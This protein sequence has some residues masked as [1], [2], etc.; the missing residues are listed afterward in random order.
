MKKRLLLAALALVSVV[1]AFALEV[2]S[3]VYNAAGERMKI[4]GE[5]LVANG[6]FATGLDGWT[7]T[8]ETAETTFTVVDGEGPNGEAVLKSNGAT[9]DDVLSCVWGP[10]IGLEGGQTYVVSFQIKGIKETTVG[11]TVGSNYFDFFMN[12]DGAT[13]HVASTDEAPVVNI[14]SAVTGLD[15]DGWNTVAFTFD[16]A[17][18]KFVVMHLEKLASDAMVT[19]ITIQAAEKVYDIRI[20]QAKIAFAKQLMD[21]PNFNTEEAQEARTKLAN[22]IARLE[23]LIEA[24]EFD[25]ESDA[26]EK[27]IRFDNLLFDGEEGNGYLAVTTENIASDTYFRYSDITTF[28]K[29]NR[30][31]IGDGEQVG[32]FIFRGSNWWHS[33]GADYFQKFIL[34]GANNTNG[35]GSVAF[36]NTKIPAGKY[37]VAVEVRNGMTRKDWGLDFT[38]EAP[39]KGFIGKD[40]IDL[41]TIQGADFTRLYFVK[42][43]TGEEDFEAGF[44]WDGPDV[45]NPSGGVQ[46][47]SFMIRSFGSVADYIERLEA[48]EKFVE[49]YNAAVAAR[50]KVISLIG[51]NNYPWGKDSLQ[52]ALVQWDPYYNDIMAK[53][54][55]TADGKDAG[56]ATIDELIE[57]AKYQG[58][59]PTL[60]LEMQLVRGYQYAGNYVTNLNK[61]LTD[62]ATDIDEAKKIRNK[63]TNASG[64]RETYKTAILAAIATLK[65]VR[66][67]TTDA[68]READSTT[69]SNAQQTLAIATE[70]F[71][72]SAEIKPVVDIDFANGFQEIQPE[73]ETAES[74]YVIKGNAGEMK[75]PYANV[76]LDNAVADWNWC[77]GYNGELTDVLHVSGNSYATVALPEI[78]DTDVLVINFDLWYGQLGKGFMDVDLLNAGGQRVAG[79]SYDCYNSNVSYNDFDN[80]EGTGMVIKGKVKSNHDKN[81]GAVSIC[82]DAL[83]N[84]FSLNIDYKNG[85]IQGGV[86]NSSNKVEGVAIPMPATAD[87]DNKITTFRIGSNSYQKANSGANGRRCWFDN[88]KIQKYAD[89]ASDFEEDITESPWANGIND[90]RGTTAAPA[91]IYSLTGVKLNGVPAK[92]L[93]I[94]NGK[95]YIV[96]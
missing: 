85:T 18:G 30:G 90:V 92:G 68:T 36:K 49:Q 29:K 75:F 31:D 12:G 67:K 41:G 51:D 14:A 24:G 79:F 38:L 71:L 52:N 39:I 25:D 10:E 2:D 59:N 45:V 16:Y 70:A 94:M 84:S 19:N 50:E 6:N 57:W 89:A 96:K 3:Y 26:E 69:V 56:T 37:F 33:S 23:S 13:A 32:G 17:E 43:F 46:M 61:P 15:A 91:G 76:Q 7:L 65:D 21:D 11:T 8:G 9:A 48:W 73:D 5:N 80:A 87:G 27:M 74:Y 35:P 95:K 60:G 42:E 53:G 78:S 82:T 55:V 77:L 47:R 62:F 58:L 44:Y 72:A 83:R 20:A 22:W 81:G 40:S 93:Y 34:P 28:P 54:W 86:V 4:T 63:G 66:S 64:D 88:L 1:G